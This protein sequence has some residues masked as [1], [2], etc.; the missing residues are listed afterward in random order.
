M[1]NPMAVDLLPAA[2]LGFATED[3]C[4]GVYVLDENTGEVETIRSDRVVLAT[5]GCGKVYLFT[6]NPDIANREGV[7]MAGRGG[8]EVGKIEVMPFYSTCLFYPQA[9]S[10]LIFQA[11]GGGSGIFCK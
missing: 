7:G 2:K 3:R 6:T 5:G 1:E 9:Q 8:G 10:F 4:L 11:G